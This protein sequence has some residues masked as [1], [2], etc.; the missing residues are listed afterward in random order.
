MNSV[1]QNAAQDTA[2]GLEKTL[3]IAVPEL[4]RFT[5]AEAAAK[6]APGKW[7]KKE[8]LGHL[9][10]SALNNHQRFI[11]AQQGPLELPGYEQD[12]WVAAQ[13]YQDTDW[14]TL[15]LLWAV[16]NRHL[17]RVL[18]HMPAA[19]LQQTCKIGNHAPVTLGYIVEDYLVHLHHHLQQ[20]QVSYST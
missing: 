8:I 19:A 9:V 11:R 10:D 1:E 13:G 12:F 7:S 3:T 5:E 16:V 15:I 4:R 17:I 14:E 18:Q 6:P 20:A 2:R